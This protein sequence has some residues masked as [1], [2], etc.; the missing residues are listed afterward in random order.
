M[1][2]DVSTEEDKD[3]RKSAYT[4]LGNATDGVSITLYSVVHEPLVIRALLGSQKPD[5]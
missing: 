5:T 4:R 2:Y 3:L 1:D